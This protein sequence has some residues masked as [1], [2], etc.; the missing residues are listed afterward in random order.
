MNIFRCTDPDQLR[1]LMNQDAFE[2]AYA[3]GDLEPAMWAYSEYWG[4]EEAGEL[5]AFVLFYHGFV[6]PSLTAFGA[7]AA[8]HTI[9]NAIHL[10]PEVFY[11]IN[12]QYV[13]ATAQH[14]DMP[15]LGNLY[16]MVIQPERYQAPAHR[17]S[18][19]RR[20]GGDDVAA[21]NNLYAQAAGPHEKIVAFSPLQ[22]ETGC[23]MGAEQ[24]GRLIAAAGTHVL[25]VAENIAAVGNVFTQPGVR[26]R[27]MATLTTAAVT[28]TVFEMGI[29]RVI[30]NVY[31]NNQPAVH[32]YQKL[33]YQIY[34]TLVEGTGYLK[35]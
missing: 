22:V 1:I 35:N 11:M 7:P 18:K 9:L 13:E 16:R 33:G 28:E 15:G 26:G 25:S 23:F 34:S 21:L 29:N 8:V 12:D 3:L 20:L 2:A 6:S 32:V 14:Y 24:D 17:E 19:V 31:Q 4:A 10:P 5:Q 27:G 30:L